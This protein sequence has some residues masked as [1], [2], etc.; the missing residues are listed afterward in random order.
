MGFDWCFDPILTIFLEMKFFSFPKKIT[1]VGSSAFQKNLQ[2]LDQPTLVIFLTFLEKNYDNWIKYKWT[3]LI[4][5]IPNLPFS[6][7]SSNNSLSDRLDEHSSDHNSKISTHALLL[8]DLDKS[9]QHTGCSLSD[10]H[11][12]S[13][14]NPK[15]ND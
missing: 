9:H 8:N 2:R 3:G 12:L 11:I 1:S 4:I 10:Q 7:Y 15:Y 14:I 5:F 13:P 6:A